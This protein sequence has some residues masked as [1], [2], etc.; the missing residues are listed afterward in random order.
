MADIEL[1]GVEGFTEA[2][3]RL[4][5]T[6][7][8]EAAFFAGGDGINLGD[9]ILPAD[10]GDASLALARLWTARG[11]KGCTVVMPDGDVSF[12]SAVTLTV[13]SAAAPPARKLYQT[14]HFVGGLD[15]RVIID[16]PAGNIFNFQNFE[17][18]TFEGIIFRGI[19]GRTFDAN[20]VFNL[21]TIQES[22][23]T[24]CQFYGVQANRIIN[25]GGSHLTLDLCVFRGT[26]G[27]A[28]YT[29]DYS[30]FFA[31]DTIFV[32]Y[33]EIDGVYY[34]KTSGSST[35][36]ITLKNGKKIDGVYGQRGALAEGCSF[37]EAPQTA[38]WLENIMACEIT[39]CSFNVYTATNGAAV[40]GT[41]CGTIEFKYNGI[42]SL[43][44]NAPHWGI[45][46]GCKKIIERDNAYASTHRGF[47][48]HQ[49]YPESYTEVIY[50]KGNSYRFRSDLIITGER[51]NGTG[52]IGANYT[53]KTTN[54][55]FAAPSATRATGKI[56]LMHTGN[57]AYLRTNTN[58]LHSL[59]EARAHITPHHPL[60]VL[61]RVDEITNSYY[62]LRFGY[63]DGALKWAW[64]LTRMKNGVSTQLAQGVLS[65]LAGSTIAFIDATA[66]I[67]AQGDEIIVTAYYF[68]REIVLARIKDS[69]PLGIGKSGF[70]STNTLD[71]EFFRVNQ[72][73]PPQ[74]EVKITAPKI[75]QSIGG[76]YL[77][78]AKVT[79]LAQ[80]TSLQF[81]L[82]GKPIGS[83]IAYSATGLYEQT[84]NL[85]TFQNGE[86]EISVEIL[87][88]YGN[89]TISGTKLFVLANTSLLNYALSSRGSTISTTGATQSGNLA[90]LIDGSRLTGPYFYAGS[91]GWR[92][93]AQPVAID[94]TFPSAKAVEKIIV[95]AGIFTASG[96]E[97]MPASD[98]EYGC[99][100]F[101][102]QTWNGTAWVTV[103]GGAVTSNTKML[104]EFTFAAITTT[105][106]RVNVT[107]GS[108]GTAW[109]NEIEAYAPRED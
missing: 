53:A 50:D 31:R 6:R 99:I 7:D 45:F 41:N 104:R 107:G 35:A 101:D 51:F 2:G 89:K 108:Y 87:D 59:T 14:M 61:S 70:G 40:T 4:F 79:N 9:Y 29:D 37:D 106:I 21:A 66:R 42:N 73:P 32:D 49:G 94:V 97:P 74:A 24:R 93:T 33:G 62:M 75:A 12:K 95:G 78:K 81:L 64:E 98:F 54:T 18:V 23:F 8:G 34:G 38:L 3:N 15:T 80:F 26:G 58:L 28:V 57:G 36:W 5:G 92:S 100:N 52:A 13:S 102:V 48:T 11:G 90:T 69:D 17:Q 39:K 16:N 30:Q 55:F 20:Y 63:I 86:K 83:S 44:D 72:L 19:N 85:D 10:N 105:K 47:V 46:T 1:T 91:G 65:N 109:L 22:R 25:F 103:P 71:V 77:F 88:A 60:I 56:S 68:G 67:W 27:E 82:D 43:G 96:A 84:I 76:S